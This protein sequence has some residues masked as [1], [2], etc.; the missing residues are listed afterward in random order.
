MATHF[1]ALELRAV[2][3]LGAVFRV[4]SVVADTDDQQWA[5]VRAQHAAARAVTLS[6]NGVRGLAS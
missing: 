4:H 1:A 5:A 2:E 6:F 3:R